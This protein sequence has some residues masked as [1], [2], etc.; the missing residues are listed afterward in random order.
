MKKTIILTSIVGILALSFISSAQAINE[1]QFEICDFREVC[2]VI[3]ADD[4]MNDETIEKIWMQF[5]YD[6]D[7]Y[8]RDD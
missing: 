3:N 8:G 1:D 7:T 2:I 5:K 4:Y 6:L